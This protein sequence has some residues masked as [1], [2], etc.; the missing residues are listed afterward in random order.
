MGYEEIDEVSDIRSN[1]GLR[2]VYKLHEQ[3]D[4]DVYLELAYDLEVL[5]RSGTC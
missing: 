1:T 5:L 4:D 3:G 2:K